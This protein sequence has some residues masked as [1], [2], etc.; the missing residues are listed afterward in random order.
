V[1]RDTDARRVRGM[2]RVRKL[3]DWMPA[4]EYQVGVSERR[5]WDRVSIGL[6]GH[7]LQKKHFEASFSCF[8]W[9]IVG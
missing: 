2:P 3:P 9:K 7:I 6:G 5:A 1:G 4:S 8:T